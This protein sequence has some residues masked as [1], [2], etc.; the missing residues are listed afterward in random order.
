MEQPDHL[1]QLT[2]SAHHYTYQLPRTGM[3]LSGRVNTSTCVLEWAGEYR[4]ICVRMEYRYMCL[5]VGG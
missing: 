5:G 3:S 2:S 1:L 4:Y